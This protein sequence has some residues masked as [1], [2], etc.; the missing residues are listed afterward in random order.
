M[1]QHLP[2]HCMSYCPFSESLLGRHRNQSPIREIRAIEKTN[3]DITSS[4]N[5]TT[6]PGIPDYVCGIPISVIHHF[7]WRPNVASKQAIEIKH[8]TSPKTAS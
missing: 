6:V 2:L 8:Y 4:V 5:T 3:I 7:A 1:I